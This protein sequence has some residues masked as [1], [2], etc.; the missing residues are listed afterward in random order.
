MPGVLLATNGRFDPVT[1]YENIRI[2]GARLPEH[3]VT[4]VFY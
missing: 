4:G 1:G 2:A 3:P